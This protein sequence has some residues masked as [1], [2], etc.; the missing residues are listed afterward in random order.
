MIRLLSY[1]LSAAAF[2][3]IN[4]VMASASEEFPPQVSQTDSNRSGRAGRQQMVVTGMVTDE[5]GEPLPGVTIRQGGKGSAAVTDL[6]GRYSISLAANGKP[7]LTFTY[8]GMMPVTEQVG[9]RSV[10]NVQL[11]QDARALDDVVVIG[12]Y[13]TAQKRIDQVGSAFQ[14]NASDLKGLP[15]ARVD[16]MIDGLIP[17]VKI[18][19]NSDSPDSPRLRTN[20]RIRGEASL[21][22]SNEPLWI[23]D[24]TP[25]YTGDRTNQ[26]PGMSV[27]VSPLSYISSE[28][29]E[30]ITVL[31]DASATSIYGADGSNGVIL[32]TTKRGQEGKINTNVSVQ[33]GFAN[34]DRSTLPKVLN[35]SQYMTLAREAWANAGNDPA[36]F[37]YADNPNNYYSTTDT[38]WSK[39][40]YGTG[41][42]IQANLSLRGGTRTN[43]YYVS[44]SYYE[45]NGTVKGNKQQRFSIRSNND[46]TFL[47]KLTASVRLMASYNNNDMFNPGKDYYQFLPIFTPYN[48]D[49]TPRLWNTF[50]NGRND[51]GTPKWVKSRFLNSVAEREENIHK[52]KTWYLNANFVLRY[53][54]LPGLSYTGQFGID[55]SSGREEQYDAR[56]NWSG[57]STT[58]GG[59]GYSTRSSLDMTNWTTV[60]RINFN[61]TFAEKHD[62]GA[63][64]GFEAGSKDHVSIGA[65]GSGFIND[66]VQDVTYANERKGSNSSST[67]RKASLLAQLSYSFDHRYYLVLNGRRDGNSQFGSDVRWANFG[68]VGVSWNIQNEKFWQFDWLDVCKLKLS[69]GVNGNSRLGSQQ[70]LGL[71]S[72]GSSYAYDGI[73]GGVQSGCPNSRLSWETTYMLN[74]G[75]RLRFLHRFDI[76]FEGY[77]NQTKNLLSNLDVS[78]TTG[79]TKV[80]RNVGEILNQG[81]EVTLTSENFV[82]KRDG[83]FGWTT[84]LNISHN[85]NKL[86]K[87]YNGIQKNMGTTSTWKEG[88]DTNTWFLV[89]WAGVDPRDGMPLW[90]D[91]DGNVTRTYSYND[92][93]PYKNPSPVV[94]GGFINTFQYKRFSLR[95]SINYAFGGYGFTT[96]GRNAVSDGYNIESENQSVDQL[97]RWQK[98]GDL[99]LNPK[100]IWHV[101]TGSVMNSTRYLYKKTNIRLQNV[102]LTYQFPR[103]LIKHARLTS[104]NVAV[105]A[106]NLYAWTPGIRKNYNSYRTVMCGFPLERTFSFQ[107]SV[108]F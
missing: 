55:Y 1:L 43:K 97:D 75:L 63:V 101:S 6:E 81:I 58:E 78:R 50:I 48:E 36:F 26:I 45:N 100:P 71:Y 93:V 54:I 31:K 17:G 76:E 24:G 16:Q 34:I 18:D 15:N 64:F 46:F 73:N 14:V 108:G 9:K 72:Y 33:Y 68:S 30:S 11:K 22:S 69:Y 107:I 87:L 37:P 90:Y 89:R 28:D 65:T 84:T 103:E 91:I 7:T 98:P 38:D 40:F 85:R 95:V 51:D 12:A 3:G 99:A 94:S 83:D 8:V 47:E 56:T 60:H 67:T 5:A 2:C 10:I 86:L 20:V 77:R 27:A 106:D 66:H 21:S 13:G 80:Y 105:I 53:D 96:F 25:I 41:N 19:L 49:G 62:V 74:Y 4:P 61:R 104:A 70:A 35:G 44:G 29:I 82:P 92:R 32:I 59:I 23:V 57:M 39:V 79:D 88:Y 42:T 52:Q 102:M